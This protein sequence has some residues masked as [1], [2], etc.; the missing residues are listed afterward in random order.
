MNYKKIIKSQQLR[1]RIMRLLQWVPDCIMIRL[2]YRVKLGFW[3]NLKHP[4][5]YTEKLQLYKMKYR[6]PIM[7]QCVDKYE[8]RKYVE[9][10]GLGHILNE[11]YGVYDSSDEIDFSKLPDK[12]VVKTTTG[13]GGQNV[14]V[15]TDKAKCNIVELK[16]KLALWENANNLGALAGREWA[17]KD[18]KPRIIIEKFLINNEKGH[19]VDYKFFC[20]NGEPKFLYVVADRDPGNYAYIGI[21]DIKFQ[22]LPVYRCDELRPDYVVPKPL[23]YEEMI[24]IARKLSVDFPHVRVDFYNIDGKIYFGELTFYDGSGYFH[25]DPDSFD[26][27]MGRCFTEY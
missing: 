11:L 19:L 15:V 7:H 26:F 24:E 3:P 13:G 16:G 23:N 10:K 14:I 22:K 4:E 25:Y 12:F 1:F 8:V 5:R 9:S 2:Q 21:Y 6:N 27:E 20:F 18:C 17:Y